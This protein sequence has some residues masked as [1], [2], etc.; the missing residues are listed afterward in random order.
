M[1]TWL[2]SFVRIYV[3]LYFTFI[4]TFYCP[5]VSTL[6]NDGLPYTNDG[7][8][9]VFYVCNLPC[10]EQFAYK[11]YLM[12]YNFEC[13]LMFLPVFLLSCKFDLVYK[14]VATASVV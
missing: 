3:H 9:Y 4:F 5:W 13:L 2:I 1:E 8:R 7:F 11:I 10:S 14:L 6:H 12:L